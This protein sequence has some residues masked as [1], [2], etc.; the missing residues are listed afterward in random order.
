MERS[1]ILTTVVSALVTALMRIGPILLLSR[2]RLPMMLQQWLN[3]IPASIMA[4]I[5]AAELINKP[6]L[7]SSGIS[8]SLLAA[9]V[10]T[11]VGIATR[12]LFAT[13]IVGMVSFSGFSYF[14][15]L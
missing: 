15:G 8:V 11:I 12:S 10:A 6:A 9:L 2:F 7:T 14:L 13:V 1:I 4:A 5:V 3:F